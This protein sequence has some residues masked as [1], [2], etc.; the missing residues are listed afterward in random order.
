MN[1]RHLLL[2]AAIAAAT[3]VPEAA[4]AA[5]RAGQAVF[6]AQCAVC[7]ATGR[8][9]APAL[10]DRKAWATR[11]DRGLG[12]LTESAI[13][14]VRKMPPHGGKLDLPDLE[15]KRAI[16]YMVNQSGGRWVEPIDPAQPQKARTGEFIVRT[17]CAGC[18]AEGKGGAPKL[19]DSP[20][21]I[22]RAK[23]GVDHLLASAIKGHGGMPG[24]GGMSDLTD[25]ELKSAID[26]M[27][28]TSV[29]SEPAR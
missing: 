28:R 1:A 16:A 29:R 18:H 19:G 6:E 23:A 9:G 4:P 14:G 12:A 13:A 15:I 8:E 7:H 20:A 11:S 21:W 22:G 26:H 5:A 3:S 10:G 24:R 27:V 17:Q 2:C 25:A